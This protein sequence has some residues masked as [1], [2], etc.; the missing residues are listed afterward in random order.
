[1]DKDYI[2]DDI[3]INAIDK[4]KQESIIKKINFI[5]DKKEE[6]KEQFKNDITDI[7]EELNVNF[8]NTIIKDTTIFT[9]L[10]GSDFEGIKIENV[11]FI[12]SNIKEIKFMQ[13]N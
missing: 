2:K 11:E 7:A 3:V 5:M 12:E 4:V 8:K 9:N 13:R 6:D 10:D 1:M